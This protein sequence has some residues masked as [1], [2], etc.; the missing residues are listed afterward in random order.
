VGD[1]RAI[2]TTFWGSLWK[3][4]P[5]LGC[6][7]KIEDVYERAGKIEQNTRP[8]AM[9]LCSGFSLATKALSGNNKLFGFQP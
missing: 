4:Y 9:G 6:L 2:V 7:G 8:K 5:S 3:N 1:I